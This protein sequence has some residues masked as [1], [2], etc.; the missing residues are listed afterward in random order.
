MSTHEIPIIKYS[1]E[2]PFSGSQIQLTGRFTRIHAEGYL[3][4]FTVVPSHL[5]E[6][7]IHLASFIGE[8]RSC[9]TSLRQLAKEL[10]LTVEAA[11]DRLWE[12]AGLAVGGEPLIHIEMVRA[13]PHKPARYGIHIS[14]AVPVTCGNGL[15]THEVWIKHFDEARALAKEVSPEAYVTLLALAV[16]MTEEREVGDSLRRLADRWSRALSTVQRAIGELVA[17]G[18]LEKMVSPRGNSYRIPE[19]VPLRFG[20]VQDSR[21][22]WQHLKDAF[23]E[24]SGGWEC[25]DLDHHILK[26]LKEVKEVGETTTPAGEGLSLVPDE[27][28]VVVNLAAMENP[29]SPKPVLL[30]TPDCAEG[31]KCDTRDSD[32]GVGS[33]FTS[34]ASREETLGWAGAQSAPR[35]N[36]TL[37]GKA[38]DPRPFVAA[39]G[40]ENV[41][42]WF[43]QFGPARCMEVWAKAEAARNP[44][45]YMRRALEQNWQWAEPQ[46]AVRPRRYWEV[47]PE[48]RAEAQ[49]A[50]GEKYFGVPR[51]G[52]TGLADRA[53]VLAGLWEMT[54]SGSARSK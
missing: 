15:V 6:T 40:R 7:L 32:D 22:T 25:T 38:E 3:K 19:I 20:G 49:A 31:E 42:R 12:L 5:L 11:R 17:A 9:H 37:V 8:T 18:L 50:I 30:E 28:G 16:E 24:G 53:E 46:E 35:V 47:T 48:E 34:V 23:G 21:A 14:D 43:G 13:A 36:P 10:G 52:D 45:G 4:F 51:G 1:S 39:V 26:E 54:R 27:E 33:E 44:V 29:A 41:R 2:T